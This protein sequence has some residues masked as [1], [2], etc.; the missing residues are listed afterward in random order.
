MN[1]SNKFIVLGTLMLAPLGACDTSAEECFAPECQG[2]DDKEDALAPDFRRLE[3]EVVGEGRVSVGDE[4][5]TT[6]QGICSFDVPV[7]AVVTVTG[8]FSFTAETDDDFQQGW[9]SSNRA[10]RLVLGKSVHLVADL[11]A[12]FSGE[13]ALE[14]RPVDLLPLIPGIV[15]DVFETP[16]SRF[17]TAVVQGGEIKN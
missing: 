1:T 2:F 10:C 4:T 16:Y 6:A 3:V 14:H 12:D 8:D 17:E 7:G 5:C 9:C 11:D 13:P 15:I